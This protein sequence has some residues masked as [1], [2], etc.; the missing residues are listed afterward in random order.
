LKGMK[1]KKWIVLVMLL[2]A[3]NV[4]AGDLL[5]QGNFYEGK[6]NSIWQ[7]GKG[8][9]IQIREPMDSYNTLGVNLGFQQLNLVRQESSSR[10]K[11]LRVNEITDGTADVFKVGLAAIRRVNN[12]IEAEAGINYLIID[13]DVTEAR[14]MRM[15]PFKKQRTKNIDAGNGFLGYVGGN[16]KVP[17]GSANLVG[18]VGYQWEIGRSEVGSLI[19]DMEGIYAGVGLMISLN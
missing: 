15:G 4:L 8:V 18:S 10:R 19:N 13:S 17:L 5:V 14:T 6:K 16:V 9:G 2:V 3:T 12:S 7:D 1:M 11:C